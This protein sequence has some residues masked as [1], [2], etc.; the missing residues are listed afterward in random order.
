MIYW[1]AYTN[2]IYCVIKTML[3]LMFIETP[4]LKHLKPR[5]NLVNS[6][7]PY[8]LSHLVS[9]TIYMLGSQSLI[10]EILQ[11]LSYY[12]QMAYP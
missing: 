11:K 12:N 1:F 5:H 3:K 7:I 8:W 4:S 10:M 2:G 6:F 9:W